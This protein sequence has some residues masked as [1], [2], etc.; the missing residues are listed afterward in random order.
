MATIYEK[1]DN[2]EGARDQYGIL[3]YE[4][5]PECFDEFRYLHYEAKRIKYATI[6]GELENPMEVLKE[7]L[8][9]YE[10]YVDRH[11]VTEEKLG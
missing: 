2:F 1:L 11:G 7:R 8:K 4:Y 9:N 5:G 3:T 6:L 10:A